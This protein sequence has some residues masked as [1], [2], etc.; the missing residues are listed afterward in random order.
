M[1]ADEYRLYDQNRKAGT[2]IMDLF[3]YRFTS[4]V[5]MLRI[6]RKCF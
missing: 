3:I 1:F 5:E 4:N 6:S 2:T